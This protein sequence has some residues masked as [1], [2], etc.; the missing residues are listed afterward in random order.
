MIADFVLVYEEDLE[1]PSKDD[2]SKKVKE[3]KQ[4]ESFRK[5]YMTNLRKAGVEMEEVRYDLSLSLV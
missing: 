1:L 5:K 4:K 2:K 3:R